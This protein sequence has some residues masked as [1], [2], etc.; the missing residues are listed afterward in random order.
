MQE[1]CRVT[2]K[3]GKHLT[4]PDR[5]T[6][7]PK[8][9]AG[10]DARAPLGWLAGRPQVHSGSESLVEGVDKDFGKTAASVHG[11][12]KKLTASR[13][14]APATAA[15][16]DPHEHPAP[17]VNYR[18]DGQKAFAGPVADARSEVALTRRQHRRAH[19][20]EHGE[21]RRGRAAT[22]KALA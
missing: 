22:T 21:K 16:R 2:R 6:P 3:H 13:R 14:R 18:R 20:D 11:P 5:P 15:S 8:S 7:T 9:A 17:K 1:A 4:V 12:P 10:R 19:A